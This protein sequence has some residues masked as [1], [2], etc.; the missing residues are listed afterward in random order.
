MA[1]G[2]TE[3]KSMFKDNHE[4]SAILSNVEATLLTSTGRIADLETLNGQTE[5]KL[6]EAIGSRD[7]VRQTIKQEL[8]IDEFTPDAVRAKLSTYASDDVLA[9]RDEQFNTLRASSAT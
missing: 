1:D 3:L 8:G 7:K 9:A 2:I 6:N 5:N 4:A